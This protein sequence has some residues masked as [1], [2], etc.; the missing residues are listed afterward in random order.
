MWCPS[1]ATV[2]LL[3]Q[4]AC[5][6]GSRWSTVV[7]SFFV[8]QKEHSNSNNL[9][10]NCVPFSVKTY[11]GI[12]YLIAQLSINNNKICKAV[13]LDVGTTLFSLGKLLATTRT[14]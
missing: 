8:F 1:H 7:D 14:D 13:V 5:L 10:T 12:P 3:K 4:S 11:L 9:R 2:V 6:L